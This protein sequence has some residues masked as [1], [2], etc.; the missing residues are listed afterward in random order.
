MQS[1]VQNSREVLLERMT[2]KQ[3]L[4]KEEQKLINGKRSQTQALINAT[5]CG[6]KGVGMRPEPSQ[7]GGEFL[8]TLGGAWS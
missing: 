5:G 8:W 6:R 3:R 4:R 2:C 1:G 7:A